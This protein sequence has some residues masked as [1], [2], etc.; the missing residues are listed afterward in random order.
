MFRSLLTIFRFSS[1]AFKYLLKID[2]FFSNVNP[3]KYQELKKQ[4]LSI[5]SHPD[6]L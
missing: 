3:P 6:F 1:I 5:D 2:L 4:Y